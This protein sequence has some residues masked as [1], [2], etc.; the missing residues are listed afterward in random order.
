MISFSQAWGQYKAIKFRIY[1]LVTWGKMNF[2]IKISALPPSVKPFGVI[3]TFAPIEM[4][5]LS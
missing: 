1:L 5:E 2:K 4:L 3:S